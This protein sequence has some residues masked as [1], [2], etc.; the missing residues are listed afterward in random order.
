MYLQPQF[1]LTGKIQ[2]IFLINI[3]LYM[4]LLYI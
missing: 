1:E 4:L 3:F 2:D